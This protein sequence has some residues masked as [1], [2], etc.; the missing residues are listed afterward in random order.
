MRLIRNGIRYKE[1]NNLK[2]RKD[3]RKVC[4]G[5][6]GRISYARNPIFFN[7]IASKLPEIQFKWIGDGILRHQLKSKN[8]HITGWLMR[9]EEGLKSLND[10][11]IYLQTS[12]WY[13]LSIAVIEAMALEKPVIATN[14]I[15][16]KDIVEHGKTGFLISNVTQAINAIEK[17]K[18]EELRT[19]MGKCGSL[20]VEKHFNSFKN[21]KSLIDIYMEGYSNNY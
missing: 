1:I 4:V 12:L 6:L 19:K 21:F 18:C 16:N 10:V 3:K 8:I 5:I 14:V 17:L 9:R 13:L 11:D 2:I 20:R 15:G 7:E